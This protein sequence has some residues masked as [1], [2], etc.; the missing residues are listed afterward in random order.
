MNSNQVILE[1]STQT[2]LNNHGFEIQRRNA[3]NDGNTKWANIA[4][5]EGYGNSNSPKLYSY[6]DNNIVGGSKFKYRLKQIDIDGTF[7]YSEEIEVV[8]VPTEYILEQNYPNPFN[9][10]TNIKFSLPQT[11]NTKIVV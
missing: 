6:Y 5:V 7:E 8:I 2:E 9:P 1:W 11:S 3:T 4:F 10:K